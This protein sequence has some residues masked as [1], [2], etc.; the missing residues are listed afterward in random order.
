MDEIVTILR[1]GM[2][3]E[4]PVPPCSIIHLAASWVRNQ[5]PLDV[6]AEQAVKALLAR[7]QHV[8]TDF[9]C[10]PCVVHQQIEPA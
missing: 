1:E 7:V 2:P 8:R 9:R 10:N 3:G 6:Y 5:G 4:P